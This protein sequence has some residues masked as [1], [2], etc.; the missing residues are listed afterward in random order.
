[1]TRGF[2]IEANGNRIYVDGESVGRLHSSWNDDRWWATN[3]G[4]GEPGQP[5]ICTR[6]HFTTAVDAAADLVS[7]L[8]RLGV[9][10]N[11]SRRPRHPGEIPPKSACCGVYMADFGVAD[12]VLY[13]SS[14]LD[15]CPQ[16]GAP[17]TGA[18][19]TLWE[20]RDLPML[21]RVLAASRT[22]D[23]LRNLSVDEE[24]SIRCLHAAGLVNS[25]SLEL[26]LDRIYVAVN[27]TPAGLRALGEWP[28]GPA[29]RPTAYNPDKH[30][31]KQRRST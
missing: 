20:S 31:A 2:G 16:C 12:G 29:A 19:P 10:E 27:I 22:A 25:E 9:I 26:D 24:D 21:R 14:V 8:E 6:V 17:A 3:A 1:M 4:N 18:S 30:G 11:T 23:Q 13:E 5:T 15:H 28:G 7:M